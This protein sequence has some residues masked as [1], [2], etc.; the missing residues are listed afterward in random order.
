M[1]YSL[2]NAWEIARPYI[3]PACEYGEYS[4][5][6]IEKKIMSLEW[7]VW[8]GKKSAWVTEIFTNDLGRCMTMPYCGGDLEELIEN[9]DRMEQFARDIGCVKL[10]LMGRPGW[11]RVFREKG[12]KEEHIIGK[13]L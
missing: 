5:E 1:D 2:Q 12:F 9:Y 3:E 13:L 7:Q 10:Y 8:L 6:M 4:I 11:L